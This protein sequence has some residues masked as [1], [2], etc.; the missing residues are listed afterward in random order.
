MTKSDDYLVKQIA[1]EVGYSNS[2]YFPKV[3]HEFFGTK[4]IDKK[5][6]SI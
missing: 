6:A 2:T 1:K 5:K 4:P 3:Y